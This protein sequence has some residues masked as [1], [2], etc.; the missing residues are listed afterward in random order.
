M[1]IKRKS[2]PK[3]IGRGRVTIMPIN[4]KK[5]I[6]LKKAPKNLIQLKEGERLKNKS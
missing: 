6:G 3:P 5:P 1:P 2:K 4:P